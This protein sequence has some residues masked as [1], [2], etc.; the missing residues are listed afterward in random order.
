MSRSKLFT[1]K[2]RLTRSYAMRESESDG[3]CLNPPTHAE[4]PVFNCPTT[5]A[6]F[7]L[8]LTKTTGPNTAAPSRRPISSKNSTGNY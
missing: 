6:G 2:P 8:R 7:P 5:S 3:M 1:P 4:I